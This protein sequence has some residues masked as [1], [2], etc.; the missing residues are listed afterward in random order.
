[1]KVITE[2]IASLDF[3]K[4]RASELADIYNSAGLLLSKAN[5]GDKESYYA[6]LGIFE[7]LNLP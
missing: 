3:S 6:C 5:L 1:M 4:L 2:L 7:A